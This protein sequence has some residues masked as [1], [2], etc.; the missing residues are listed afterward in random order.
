MDGSNYPVTDVDPCAFC[1]FQDRP[2]RNRGPFS[3]QKKK[4]AISCSLTHSYDAIAPQELFLRLLL[5]L[6]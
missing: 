5:K 3:Q 4:G 1:P 2:P 6:S